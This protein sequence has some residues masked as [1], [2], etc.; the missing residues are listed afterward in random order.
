MENWAQRNPGATTSKKISRTKIQ[1][2]SRKISVAGK[3]QRLS[4][5][6]SSQTAHADLSPPYFAL[7]E[8]AFNLKLSISTIWR[9]LLSGGNGRGPGFLIFGTSRDW[10]F[11][12]ATR[13]RDFWFLT[14]GTSETDSLNTAR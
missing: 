6:K 3:L 7:F 4:P 11:L 5:K 10:F 2:F 14:L 12:A 1:K 13:F 8:R 9:R